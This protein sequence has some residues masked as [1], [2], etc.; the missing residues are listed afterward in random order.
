MRLEA[1]PHESLPSGGPGR[2]DDGGF[3]VSKVRA[4]PGADSPGRER[5]VRPRRAARRHDYLTMSEVQ[6]FRGDENVARAGTAT[7]SSTA[8]EGHAQAGDRRQHASALRHGPVDLAHGVQRQS[9]VGGRSGRADARRS[10]RAV[11][12]GR[13]S[14]SHDRCARVA[15]RCRIASRSGSRRCFLAGPDRHA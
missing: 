5:E 11:E 10:R 14:V 4:V 3:V 9:V 2:A 1:L 12:R 15:A 6:V 8:Y 13:A 7:Q